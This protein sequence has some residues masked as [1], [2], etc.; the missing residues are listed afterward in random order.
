MGSFKETLKK[1]GDDFP[2]SKFTLRIFLRQYLYSPS[3]RI[4]LNY[5]LGKYFFERNSPVFRRLAKYFKA[6]MIVRRSCQFSYKCEIGKALKL[7]HPI[8][9]VIGD[10][11]IIKDNIEVYQQVTIGSHGKKGQPLAY[12]VV[13]NN[14]KIFA[15]AK[16][17]GGINIGENAII[18]ANALVNINVP[19]NAKA[20][21]VPCKIIV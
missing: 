1:I 20:V 18:G 10:G 16:I 4:L 12:P 15:G 13:E 6:Q 2:S 11:V 5:R 14:V 9:I 19:A 17:I 8:G 7:P 3:F 21:G